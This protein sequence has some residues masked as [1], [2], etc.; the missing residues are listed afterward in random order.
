ML[1][2]KI[3]DRSRDHPRAD[4]AVD[5]RH[6]IAPERN[7]MKDPEHD[8]IQDRSTH[9]G[10]RINDKL[11]KDGIEN[12]DR[13]RDLPKRRLHS[14]FIIRIADRNLQKPDLFK[15]HRHRGRVGVSV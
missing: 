14:F 1:R 5:D 7:R 3:V 8:D 9:R 12:P 15:G 13:I 6:G 2:Q 10:D 4:R 11:L